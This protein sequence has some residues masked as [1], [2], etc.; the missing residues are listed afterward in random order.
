METVTLTSNTRD[1][2]ST[3]DD[4][5]DAVKADGFQVTNWHGRR[6]WNLIG[7]SGWPCS[8]KET[9]QSLGH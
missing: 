9:F 7:V 4:L 8:Y 5:L 1:L 6:H 2:V 3:A